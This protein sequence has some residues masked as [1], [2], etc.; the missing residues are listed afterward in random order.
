MTAC[1]P[2]FHI[3][4]SKKS[5]YAVC[6]LK[7]RSDSQ[8]VAADMHIDIPWSP[9]DLEFACIMQRKAK[10]WLLLAFANCP[11]NRWPFTVNI[12]MLRH[13]VT[14]RD[15]VR[16]NIP[17]FFF[18]RLIAEHHSAMWVQEGQQLEQTFKKWYQLFSPAM[19]ITLVL[20]SSVSSSR[21]QTAW[22]TSS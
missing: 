6:M 14:K 13:V 4:N 1:A 8:S 2:P 17:A 20:I 22:L 12:C 19:S 16:I 7:L 21:G 18:Q 11:V 10:Q 5:N 3:C 9:L 15:A